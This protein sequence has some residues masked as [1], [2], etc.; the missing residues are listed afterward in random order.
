MATEKKYLSLE[1]LGY[2]DSK[3]K[4]W[5]TT[6][7]EALEAGLQAKI[8]ATN[9]AISDEA[10]R[11]KAQEATNATAAQAAQNAADAAQSDVDSLKD[12]VGTFTASE[13]VDTV[14][15]YIDAKT[16]NIASDE[17]VN[18]LDARV[19]QAEK[20]IDA[21]EADYLK[22]ADKTELEGKISTVSGAVDAEKE[23]AEGVESG[24]EDRIET[25][26]AFW[27]A[28]KADGEEENVIDTLK[29]IQDYIA[30]DESGASAMAASIKQNA[31]DIDALEESVAKK[32]EQTALDAEVTAR[33]EADSALDARVKAIES[34]VGESGSVAE[35]I[36]T[37]KDE[38]IATAAA[39]ATTKANAALTDGK[40]YTDT[41]VGKDRTRL[42]ALETASA[43]HALKTD[44]DAVAEKVTT[45]E[46]E[47][48][49]LQTDV[50]AVEA[51]AAANDAAIKALQTAS[52]TH[53]L[54][55]D[56][57][58]EVARATAAEQA[59][60]DAIAAF[61]ELTTDDIDGLF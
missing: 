28:A 22:A 17:T 24:L 44:L 3:L 38:A 26:E 40:A 30:S 51:L 48:D 10:T 61:T 25:M 32:A 59:N 37:A 23:R 4:T 20:D 21:I 8:D 16:E 60:A 43:T 53:A 11:A 58:A 49:T 33:T 18:A 1:R 9:T 52:A 57:E 41:E 56:L 14:I 54:K 42:D 12:Y 15:E 5:V 55:T 50:D 35:D 47:I 6:K 2:Y 29:E 19:E 31:D 39:D 45:A 36:A 27:E 46:G 13:G 34:A 7:D